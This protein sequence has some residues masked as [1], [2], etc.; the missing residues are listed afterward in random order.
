MKIEDRYDVIVVGA[1]PGGSRAAEVCAKGGLKTLC[2]EKRGEI[3]APKRCAEG[4]SKSA[5]ER[6]GIELKPSWVS[7]VITSARVYAPNRK[8]IRL[9][10]EGPE[11]WILERKV[12][13]KDL[14]KEAARAGA[15]VMAKAE[16]LGVKR[17]D[18]EV[19][20]RISFHGKEREVSA[21]IMVAADGV[22]SKTA[23][24]LGLDTTM[25]LGEICSGAQFEMTN[26]KIDP[27]CID[28]F[29]DQEMTP[30]GYFWIF[31]K[32]HDSANV[33]LGVRKPWS[34]K[35]A[36]EYL[37]EF[38]KNIEGLKDGSVVEVNAGAIP[39]GQLLENMVKD[40]LVVVGDAAHQVNPIHGGGIA[41]A[42]IGGTLAGET[43]VEAAKAKDFS[44]KFLSRYNERWWEQRGN[45]HKKIL[46]LRQ[47]LES[48]SN[49][50]LNWIVDYLD[51]EDIKKISKGASFAK[52]AQ[53]L[54]KKPK[55][56]MIAKKLM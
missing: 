31:P 14:A 47:A 19:K 56:I 24:M 34:K 44:E 29:F 53:L 25:P 33:G 7:Q 46:K 1:G 36:M 11:G 49:E 17:E 22:E 5:R 52:L 9:D 35:L 45:R 15:K 38:V 41:E 42:Y 48:M 20:A 8:S 16:L 3:G 12:F 21:S 4:L 39:V 28:F 30:G 26:V 51:E 23:R 40:N 13:D 32:G 54:I 18:G 50:D 43:I 2:I 10:Y 27:D 6:M 55:L 37:E